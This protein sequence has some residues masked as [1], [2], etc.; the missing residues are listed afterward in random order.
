VIVLHIRIYNET[1]TLYYI[2][3]L[4]PVSVFFEG[5]EYFLGVGMHQVGPR[6]PQRVHDVI[7]KSDL[8]AENTTVIYCN[9]VGVV[10]SIEFHRRSI[11]A[12]PV[13]FRS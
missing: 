4:V 7:D 2:L 12:L 1:I 9:R 11:V 10:L 13:I 8:L 3:T 5:V 6:L